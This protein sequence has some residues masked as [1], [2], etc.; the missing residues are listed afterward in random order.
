MKIVDA[1]VLVYAFNTDAQR[2]AEARSWLD[3]AL[4]SGA[5]VGFAWVVNLAFLRLTTRAGFFPKPASPRFAGE[6]LTDWLAQPSAQIVQPTVRHAAILTRLLAGTPATGNLV[7][8]AHLAA[9][10]IVHRATIVSDDND[11]ERF[12]GVRWERPSRP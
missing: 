3:A 6:Q 12:D 1:N 10:A 7:P 11:S 4:S 5:V 9:L 8:D 2:H